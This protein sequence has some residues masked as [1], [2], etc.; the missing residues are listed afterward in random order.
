M[1]RAPDERTLQP[2]AVRRSLLA[3][4]SWSNASRLAVASAQFEPLRKLKKQTD[5]DDALDAEWQQKRRMPDGNKKPLKG[6]KKNLSRALI[7]A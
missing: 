1:A 3:C 4:F 6:S 7:S 5:R 2:E